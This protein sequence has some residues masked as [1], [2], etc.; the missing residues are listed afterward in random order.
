MNTFIENTTT[1]V[2]PNPQE[3]FHHLELKFTTDI[4]LY[5]QSLVTGLTIQA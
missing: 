2:D 1:R 3:E 5:H 4:Y